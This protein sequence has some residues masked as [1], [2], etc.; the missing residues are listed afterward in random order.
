M[1]FGHRGVDADLAD[2]DRRGDRRRAVLVV[3]KQHPI[4]VGDHVCIG[5]NGDLQRVR[6]DMREL[7]D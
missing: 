4:A 5:R 3:G 2:L 6:V 7:Q 1:M